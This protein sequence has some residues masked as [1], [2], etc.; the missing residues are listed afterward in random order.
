MGQASGTHC[1]MWSASTQ[2]YCVPDTVPMLG[3]FSGDGSI[4]VLPSWGRIWAVLQRE[5]G[6]GGNQTTDQSTG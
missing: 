3:T 5:Q 6:L 1:F 2:A 4:M